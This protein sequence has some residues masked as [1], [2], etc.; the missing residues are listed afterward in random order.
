MIIW[1]TSHVIVHFS[2]W[3]VH[4]KSKI[5]THIFICEISWAFQEHS[6]EIISVFPPPHSFYEKKRKR[7]ITDFKIPI[8]FSI[9]KVNR[10]NLIRIRISHLREYCCFACSLDS[11]KS[12]RNL[13]YF[14]R[15][16]TFL[17][18]LMVIRTNV[19]SLRQHELLICS[20][21]H[22]YNKYG[23]IRYTYFCAFP[24][25]MFKWLAW[26]QQEVQT[27]QR[28]GKSLNALVPRQNVKGVGKFS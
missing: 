8:A 24:F 5:L 7:K 4:N 28:T 10:V 15:S 17:F 22:P 18:W 1:R 2:H 16:T 14:C 9:L 3:G 21:K 6:Q 13:F 26:I 19:G 27:N 23:N 12:T 11:F 20:V 25:H